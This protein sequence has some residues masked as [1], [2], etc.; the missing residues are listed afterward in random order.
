[1]GGSAGRLQMAIV[2][3]SCLLWL[4]PTIVQFRVAWP[5]VELDLASGFSFAPLPALARGDLDQV[6]TADPIELPGITNEPL[7]T[8]EALLAV[9]NHHAL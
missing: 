5:E 3:H 6:V 9:A 2:C 7:F 8:N 1:A 4:M